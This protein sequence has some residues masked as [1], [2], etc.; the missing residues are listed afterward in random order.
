MLER[1]GKLSASSQR[2]ILL[3]GCVVLFGVWLT[4]VP[5]TE[6]DETRYSEATREMITAGGHAIPAQKLQWMQQMSERVAH[7]LPFL[8]ADGVRNAFVHAYPAII[9]YF[10]NQVRYQKPIL[11]Y[12][13]Q[14]IP[15]RLLGVNEF[16]ARLPSAIFAIALVLLLHGFLL[17]WLPR[18]AETEA[19]AQRGRGAALLG[20]GALAMVPL[21]TIWARGATTDMTLTFFITCGLLAFL[22]ADL[23]AAST[24]EAME[25]RRVTRK[26]Y[27]LAA[28]CIALA[29]LTKGPMGL[30]P[31]F[32]WII[33]HLIQRDLGAEARRVPW[34]PVVLI[35]LLVAVPWYFAT[36]LVDGPGFLTHFF[37]EENIGR[38][39]VTQEGHGVGN[40]I[41]GLFTYLP[42]A[43]VFLFPISPTVIRDIFLP[44]SGN[45][46]LR[47]D[48]VITRLRRF[49]WTWFIATVAVFA[50]S[51]TQLPSYIQSVA[52]AIAI[53]FV[54][55]LLGRFA[56]PAAAPSRAERWG[57][58]LELALLLFLGVI[59]VGGPL[60]AL[61]QG[62]VIGP[63]GGAPFPFP[64]DLI[65]MVLVAF[66]GLV[67]LLGIILHA[68]HRRR[69][70]WRRRCSPGPSFSPC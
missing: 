22:Q 5:L 23:L 55:H 14:S 28:L 4:R 26:W 1:L 41:A 37:M 36:Y 3:L 17:Y 29:F 8:H 50:L 40:R 59:F 53:L 12:W 60:Y 61:Y 20:A 58:A 39:A 6:I 62:K 56:E 64:Y 32:V 35:L 42:V 11:Y 45:A 16:A 43:L 19:G 15:V 44:L 34:L 33:Y 49:C 24:P 57:S 10:N 31:G 2:L 48:A 30:I 69:R 21:V 70:C 54:L 67:L 52:A 63:L 46:H 25:A 13:I 18:R 66:A 27:L 47:A 7:T 65:A 38:F 51:K 68:V 9:P